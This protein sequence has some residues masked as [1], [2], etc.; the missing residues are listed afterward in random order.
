MKV[1]R[2]NIFLLVTML[3]ITQS[4]C[5]PK[6]TQQHAEKLIQEKNYQGA[7]DVYQAV[8]GA[9][10]ETP[11]AREAQLGIAKLYVEK[12]NR[13]QEGLK[14]YQDLIAA[15]S[16]SEEAARAHWDLGLYHFKAN[17]Y[18]TAQESFTAI[19]NKFPNLEDLGHNAQLMLAKSYEKTKNYKKA[20]EVYGHVANR[21]P[22]SER[23]VQA[24]TSKAKI[25]KEYLK[26][27]DEAKETYKSLV[28]RYG[29]IPGLE[30]S[31]SEAKRELELMGA[32]IPEPDDPLGTQYDRALE[33]RQARRERDRPRGGVERSRAMMS[34]EALYTDPGF[35]VSPEE[36]MKTYQDDLGDEAGTYYVTMAQ[37][38]DINFM[39]QNYRDAGALYFRAIEIAERERGELDAYTYLRLS[40]CYR[41]LGMAQRA[42]E[43]LKE[44]A[45]RNRQVIEGIITTGTSQ[46]YYKEYDKAV[47]TLTP[48]AGLNRA[49]DPEIYWK[50]GKAYQ[51]LGDPE[52]EREFF[53]RAIAVKTDHPDALQ[54]LAEVLYYRLKE[55]ERAGIF[56]DLADAK[57]STYVGEKELGDVCYKYGS[58]S[59]AKSKYSAAARIAERQKKNATT[60]LE[61][62]VLDS[63]IIY[64]KAHAAMA[65]YKSG[66][67][68]RAKE[69][70][71]ALEAEYP[72]HSL[73]PYGRGQLALLKGD[74]EAATTAFKASMDKDPN[75]DAAPI[76]LGEYYLA[77]GRAEEAIA[78]WEKFLKTNPRNRVVRRRLGELKKQVNAPTTSNQGS[79]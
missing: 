5:L 24:L 18:Q 34:S 10:P 19:I 29:K 26:N 46:L 49:K 44:S 48:I 12:M 58:Y 56:Q 38:A 68:D 37:I 6:G 20:A 79:E 55:R 76:A 22:R 59:W 75:S 27:E 39:N 16:D 67:K 47:E 33:R 3:V 36:L 66:M 43:K 77:Q 52:K 61:K 72:D 42:D 14:M 30:Q 31:L 53:E 45:R 63:K 28:K 65:A 15:A 23:A 60:E 54:S 4:A 35:G 41:K 71:D 21:H 13:R 11:E 7:I 9:K 2:F 78:L 64:A 50:L 51:G 1:A 70:V 69:A 17:D 57:G 25:E 40:I 73:I 32:P 62:R 74:A 8:I